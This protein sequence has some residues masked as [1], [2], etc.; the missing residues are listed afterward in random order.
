MRG[1]VHV[2][3]TAS[4]GRR[5]AGSAWGEKHLIDDE[6]GCGIE[7]TR[8]ARADGQAAALDLQAG[9]FAEEFYFCR[10]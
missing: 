1:V 10:A 3:E 9:D 6:Q 8:G 4:V 2:H 5:G 7:V